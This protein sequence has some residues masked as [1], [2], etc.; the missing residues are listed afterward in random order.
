MG[1][2]AVGRRRDGI[3]SLPDEGEECEFGVELGAGLGDSGSEARSCD[4][5][6]TRWGRYN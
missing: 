6:R 5:I 2:V 3:G 4:S 1:A